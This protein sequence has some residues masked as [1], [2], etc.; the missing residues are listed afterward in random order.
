MDVRGC[1]TIAALEFRLKD[2]GYDSPFAEELTSR[3]IQKGIF[4]RPLGNIVYIL[5]PYCVSNEELEQIWNFM[6]EELNCF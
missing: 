1:G 2:Q 5:P 4:L 3:A 6:E